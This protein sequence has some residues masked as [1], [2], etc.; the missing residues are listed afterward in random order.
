[1]SFGFIWCHIS[2]R[3]EVKEAADAAAKAHANK[4]RK[5]KRGHKVDGKA[6]RE[7]H[8]CGVQ[9]PLPNGEAARCDADSETPCCAPSGWCGGTVE[10]CQCP[11]CVDYRQPPKPEPYQLEAPKRI[12]LVVPFRDRGT[13][14]EKF[15]ERIQASGAPCGRVS[16]APRHIAAWQKPGPRTSEHGSPC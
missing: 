13:H 10:H 5:G 12:A 7:D 6:W 2:W 4:T 15:R 3:R 11:M 9:H 8:K 16:R 14:L 1:M